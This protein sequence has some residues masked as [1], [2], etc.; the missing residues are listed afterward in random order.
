MSK[1]GALDL[2]VTTGD[3]DTE[4]ACDDV[5]PF[6][7]LCDKIVRLISRTNSLDGPYNKAEAMQAPDAQILLAYQYQ[8]ETI[9]LLEALAE[10][11]TD[12]SATSLI[13]L[14]AKIRAF[15]ALTS[16]VSWDPQDLDLLY[17]SIN[18]DRKQLSSAFPSL[19]L[20]RSTWPGWLL[21]GFGG[22]PRS[23]R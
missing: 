3:F 5:A 18:R 17:A 13:E 12:R 21:R 7:D 9:D 22:Y 16:L 11:V 4:G 23:L 14:D 6:S 8:A 1:L 20:S 19:F 10:F 2:S 15:D